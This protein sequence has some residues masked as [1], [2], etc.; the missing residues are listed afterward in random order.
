M[1]T[2][3]QKGQTLFP[4]PFC[5]NS[6]QNYQS[7]CQILASQN[8]QISQDTLTERYK[9]AKKVK[10]NL[11][12]ATDMSPDEKVNF[13]SEVSKKHVCKGAKI[14]GNSQPSLQRIDLG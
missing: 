7:R 13:G 3:L 10:T 1:Q 8:A 4:H 14:K 6:S 2:D 9:P 11:S 5:N 12:H